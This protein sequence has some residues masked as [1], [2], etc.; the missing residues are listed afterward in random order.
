[1]LNE[2]ATNQIVRDLEMKDPEHGIVFQLGYGTIMIPLLPMG[3]FQIV[4]KR[5]SGGVKRSHYSRLPSG[6]WEHVSS[7]SYDGVDWDYVVGLFAQGGNMYYPVHETD[8]NGM[9]H[10]A[11]VFNEYNEMLGEIRLTVCEDHT[12]YVWGLDVWEGCRRQGIATALLNFSF[13][14]FPGRMFRLNVKKTNLGA[15]KLY[16]G[17]AFIHTPEHDRGEHLAMERQC[18]SV[19]CDFVKSTNQI[20]RPSSK[21]RGVG[22]TYI[23]ETPDGNSSD[24]WVMTVKFQ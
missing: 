22:E 21:V 4:W 3:A 14:L 24:R 18:Q 10:F 12:V 8:S 16:Q 2:E 9:V 19:V 23:A 1:M 7:I 13:S 17:C 11:H 5:T 20:C 6:D 15:L